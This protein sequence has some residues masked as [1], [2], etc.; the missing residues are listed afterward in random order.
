MSGLLGGGSGADI[1]ASKEAENTK[2]TAVPAEQLSEKGRKRRRRRA[3]G[4]TDLGT[5]QLGIPGLSG[6]GGA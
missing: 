6:G 1:P 2:R 5:P 4:M 3:S